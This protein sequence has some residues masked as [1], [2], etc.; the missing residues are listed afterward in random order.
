MT[1]TDGV[2]LHLSTSS[3]SRSPHLSAGAQCTCGGGGGGGRLDS[4][5]RVLAFFLRVMTSWLLLLASD[6]GCGASEA[7]CR[8]RSSELN[9]ESVVESTPGGKHRQQPTRQRLEHDRQR[10][11]DREGNP[12]AAWYAVMQEVWPSMC[13]QLLTSCTRTYSQRY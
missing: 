10:E 12:A 11:L 5:L 1:A 4:G 3:C 13:R 8:S 9:S 7:L 2:S 6:G